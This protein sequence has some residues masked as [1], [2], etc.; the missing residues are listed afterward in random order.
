MS[1]LITLRVARAPQRRAGKRADDIVAYPDGNSEFVEQLFASAN[2]RSAATA[3]LAERNLLPPAEKI[4]FLSDIDVFLNTHDNAPRLDDLYAFFKI[5]E[6]MQPMA[7]IQAWLK[8]R[9]GLRLIIADALVASLFV[10][11]TPALRGELVR[12]LTIFGVLERLAEN[13]ARFTQPQRIENALRW[14]QVVLPDKVLQ[15][16]RRLSPPG[17]AVTRQGV[18]DLFVVRNEWIR[19][20]AGEIAHIENVLPYELKER[21]HVRLDESEVTRTDSTESTTSNERETQSTDRFELKD[22]SSRD[23]ELAVHAEAQ[24]DTSGQYGPTKVETHLGGSLDYSQ[25]D[26]ARR[27]TTQA[28]E[29]VARAVVKVEQTV[30]STRTQRTLSRIE[31]TNTHSLKSESAAPFAGIYRWVDKIERFQV[32]RYPN[33]YLLEFQVPEPAAWIRWLYAQNA[34]LDGVTAEAPRPLTSDGKPESEQSPR[35]APDDITADNYLDLGARYYAMGLTPPPG[36]ALVSAAFQQD[37]A[38]PRDK[39]KIK[40]NDPVRY[41]KAADIAIPSGYRARHWYARVHGWG[42]DAY[43]A[44]A[45]KASILLMIGNADGMSVGPDNKSAFGHEGNVLSIGPVEIDG[46]IA[47]G[48]DTNPGYAQTQ[49]PVSLRL[50]NVRGYNVH[51]TIECEP[52]EEALAAWKIGTYEKIAEA[53]FSMKN[54]RDEQVA[55]AQVRA[56]V[57]IEGNS[58][59]RNAQ[60]VREELKKHIVAMLYR[61]PDGSN[62][63]PFKW[64]RLIQTHDDTGEPSI[65]TVEAVERATLIQFLEQAFEWEKLTYVCYPYFWADRATQWRTLAD[66]K[67]A[68]PVFAEFLRAGSARTVVSVRP[69][70]ESQVQLFLDFGV[71]WGGGTA[72]APGDENYLSVADEIRA[73]QRGPDDAERLEWWDTRLPT[74]LLWLDGAGALP[75]KPEE[76]RELG[77]DPVAP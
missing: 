66:L 11:V 55:A 54:R 7:Q 77:P 29:T 36:K 25:K 39:A 10:E 63:A 24:I 74:T 17:R 62:Q 35:L 8:E 32:F 76:H 5:D 73:I 43:N 30:R 42:E 31:E 20:E 27:A 46:A 28:R 47:A 2:P 4:G 16:A 71:I 69:G 56:G 58:P 1:D 49:L 45:V 44:G 57:S 37:T 18:A 70:F 6:G 34:G 9:N 67:S 21:K 64:P 41:L 23:V 68:D 61:E 15:V 3:K 19:Y 59:E 33:R 60:V 38:N 13:P 72:P 65:R 12:L 14:R 51:L 50:D 52:T 48:N 53:Y 75:E 26:S 40:E 22:E